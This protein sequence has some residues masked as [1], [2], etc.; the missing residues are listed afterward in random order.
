MQLCFFYLFV[1]YILVSNEIEQSAP[2]LQ[3]LCWT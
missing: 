3:P 2:K 1:Y